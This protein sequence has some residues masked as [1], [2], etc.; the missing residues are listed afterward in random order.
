[1]QAKGYAFYAQSP[2]NQVFPILT[3]TQ[4]QSLRT[5]FTFE[6]T[7][8]VDE[9]RDAVRFVTSWATPDEAVEALLQ[10]L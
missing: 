7:A 4:I 2:T 6:L 3:K 5:D 10:T 1:M 8:P 9:N